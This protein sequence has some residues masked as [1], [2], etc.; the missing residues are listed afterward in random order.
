MLPRLKCG[1]GSSGFCCTSFWNLSAEI[2]AEPGGGVNSAA[3]V[4]A[5][6]DVFADSLL[7]ADLHA[8]KDRESAAMETKKSRRFIR[9]ISTSAE[10]NRECDDKKRRQKSDD[11]NRGAET[12]KQARDATRKTGRPDERQRR[13]RSP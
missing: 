10:K 2:S 13:A 9:F 5:G 4:A 8:A 6:C 7:L 1:K 12:F 11:K 3:G